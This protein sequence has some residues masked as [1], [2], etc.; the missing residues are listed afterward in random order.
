MTGRTIALA[1]GSRYGVSRYVEGPEP[2]IPRKAEKT[3]AKP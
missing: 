3:P 2:R 1:S